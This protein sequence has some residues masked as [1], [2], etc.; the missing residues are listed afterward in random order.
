MRK[1]WK[2]PNSKSLPV[3]S[4]VSREGLADFPAGLVF[5]LLRRLGLGGSCGFVL[6][7]KY[8]VLCF[9]ILAPEAGLRCT[10][11]KRSWICV[12]LT[13]KC[14]CVA[15]PKKKICIEFLRHARV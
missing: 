6:D 10:F 8:Y 4:R 13:R 14:I 12:D 3:P 7:L 9:I 1:P 5:V 11:Q 15:L 2:A